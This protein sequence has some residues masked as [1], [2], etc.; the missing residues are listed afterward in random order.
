LVPAL[1]KIAAHAALELGRELR[2]LGSIALE[3]RL[4]LGLR[5]L[6]ARRRI[7][8]GLDLVRNHERRVLPAERLAR[9]G[10]LFGAERRAVR[11]RGA[12][13]RRRAP[14][15]RRLAADQRRAL[16]LRARGLDRGLDGLG[17]VPVDVLDDVPAVGSEARRRIVGEPAL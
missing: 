10:D 9:R 7:P 17:V 15:D 14:A 16:A 6:A 12:L 4:P 2:V 8:R 1:R 13:L 11:R 3:A 5:G